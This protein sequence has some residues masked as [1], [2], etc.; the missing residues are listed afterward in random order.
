MNYEFFVFILGVIFEI[1]Q[2]D[3]KEDYFDYEKLTSSGCAKAEKKYVIKVK[4][5]IILFF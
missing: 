3:A 2:F 4:F 1:G 5:N